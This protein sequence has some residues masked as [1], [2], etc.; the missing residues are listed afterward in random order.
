MAVG[1][2]EAYKTSTNK[3]RFRLKAANGEIIC[4][5]EEYETK[6]G[7]L[8]GIASIQ[9]NASRAEIEI[10]DKDSKKGR[11]I[12]K[13][14]QLVKKVIKEEKE[15]TEKITPK[16]RDK[17]EKKLLVSPKKSRFIRPNRIPLPGQYGPRWM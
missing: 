10:L 2:F 14:R 13:P 7:C 5:G 4:Q 11:Q 9:R 16:Q 6:Q 1:H 17:D 8:K 12:L 3:W 15:Q